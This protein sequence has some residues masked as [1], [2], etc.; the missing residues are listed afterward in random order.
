MGSTPA[1]IAGTFPEIPRVSIGEISLRQLITLFDNLQ[2]FFEIEV[3]IQPQFTEIEKDNFLSMYTGRNL[4]H[5]SISTFTE[6]N[7][8]NL[9]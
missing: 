8:S 4:K 7:N 9:I 1:G 6:E 2:L 3:N 5:Y